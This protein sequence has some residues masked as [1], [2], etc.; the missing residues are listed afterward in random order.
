MLSRSCMVILSW[1]VYSHFRIE[2]ISWPARATITQCGLAR[3]DRTG[4]DSSAVA[5]D[6]VAKRPGIFT[7]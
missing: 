1:F 5:R 2:V 7:R 3:R 6:G 4:T